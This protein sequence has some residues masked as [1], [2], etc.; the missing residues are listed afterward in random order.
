MTPED[1]AGDHRPHR[2]PVPRELHGTELQCPFRIGLR[3][4]LRV[5]GRESAQFWVVGW[6]PDLAPTILVRL[7]PLLQVP[8]DTVRLVVREAINAVIG[9]FGVAQSYDVIGDEFVLT[10]LP[11]SAPGRAR[12]ATLCALFVCSLL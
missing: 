2:H 8:Q 7:T 1:T 11:G 6:R 12:E 3:T 10:P 9:R 4:S 5:D